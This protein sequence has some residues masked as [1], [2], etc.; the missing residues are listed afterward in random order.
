M[1]EY[2]P[3]PDGQ[4][5]NF[6]SM[7]KNAIII[8]VIMG[9]LRTGRKNTKS[10]KLFPERL[11]QA[12]PY[13]NKSV[14]LD[15]DEHGPV[16]WVPIKKRWWMKAPFAWFMPYRDQKGF[17]LD[18]LGYEV[19]MA[20]DGN[21]TIGEITEQFAARH[22]TTFHEARIAVMEFIQTM[23]ERRLLAVALKDSRGALKENETD[24]STKAG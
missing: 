16:L 5:I 9:L 8:F 18:P 14:D 21:H 19:W 22:H 3:R 11:L 1:Q 24:Q 6:F 13:R 23:T 4:G 17:R 12:V 7:P 15:E 10:Q 20:C 2:F